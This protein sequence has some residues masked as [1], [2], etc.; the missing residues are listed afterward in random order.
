MKILYVTTI[1]NTINAFLI[2]HIRLLVEKG[3]QVDIACNLVQEIEPELIKFGCK[4]HNLEF[5]RSPFKKGNLKAFKKIEKIVLENGYEVVHSH[6]PIASFLTRLACRNIPNLKML[7]TAHGFHFY[8]GAPIKNWFIYYPMEKLVAR[9]TDAII[10]INQ[11]DYDSA[12][13]LKSKNKK[14]VYKIS[15]VGIDIGRFSQTRSSDKEKLRK[16]YGYAIND[17]ILIYTAELNHNKHQDMLIT[18]INILKDKIPNI[19]LLLAG[20][21]SL[22]M[23]YEEQVRVLELKDKISFLGYRSDIPNLLKLSD[24]AVSAS[25]REGLPVNV[26]EAMVTGLP[27]I[28]TDCR[29]NRDLVTQSENGFV[30]GINDTPEFAK[31]LLK[32][33]SS[34][35]LREK[36]SEKGMNIIQEYSIENVKKELNEIYFDLNIINENIDE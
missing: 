11:E 34:K 29:G 8:K 36:F 14:N 30:I 4:I 12:C 7:Y 32:L 13:K 5:Q 25:R 26:M 31:S 6:T 33:Y 24:V 10:T 23:K 35:E 2:P 20:E 18:V 15:G 1:S 9:Y 19:K 3:H 27:L 22:R 16:E 28:V 17:F 21:G